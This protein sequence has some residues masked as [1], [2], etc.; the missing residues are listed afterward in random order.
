[1]DSLARLVKFIKKV[2]KE[3]Y[4]INVKVQV[5]SLKHNMW[6]YCNFRDIIVLNKKMPSGLKLEEYWKLCL[7]EVTH[8]SINHHPKSMSVS[9]HARLSKKYENECV[10]Y[11]KDHTPFF[12]REFE[13]LKRKYPF[14]YFVGFVTKPIC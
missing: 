5:K 11:P 3:E 12:W 8:L 7:H 10:K 1:M 4:S 14:V 13:R 6:G 2:A 9:M